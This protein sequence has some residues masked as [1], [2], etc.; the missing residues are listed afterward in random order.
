MTHMM[1]EGCKRRARPDVRGMALGQIS[2]F[3]GSVVEPLVSRLSATRQHNLS[4]P[5]DYRSEQ[6]PWILDYAASSDLEVRAERG[7]VPR[8]PSRSIGGGLTL[9]RRGA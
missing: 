9:E 7:Q 4:S 6:I 8:H 2:H 3:C 1:T 5:Q